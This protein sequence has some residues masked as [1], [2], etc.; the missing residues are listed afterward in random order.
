MMASHLITLF[1]KAESDVEGSA[2]DLL[3][4]LDL[5]EDRMRDQVLNRFLDIDEWGPET[6]EHYEQA[7]RLLLVN[8]K[9]P[10][11]VVPDDWTG[12]LIPRDVPHVRVSAVRAL[13]SEVRKLLD[14]AVREAED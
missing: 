8:T 2:L 1:H 10:V 6:Q 9:S 13:A 4:A 3:E 5:V 11:W 12:G 7:P 14:L